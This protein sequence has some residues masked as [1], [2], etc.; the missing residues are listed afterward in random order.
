MQVGN[1][2]IPV[3]TMVLG[4]GFERYDFAIVAS[5]NP[6]AL[7]SV[8]ADMLWT[9]TVRSDDV[10]ALCQAAPEIVARAVKRYKSYRSKNPIVPDDWDGSKRWIHNPCEECETHGASVEILTNAEQTI[11]G[12]ACANDGDRCRCSD[13]CNGTMT[14]DGELLK[15]NWHDE[16]IIGIVRKG[17]KA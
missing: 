8:E 16:N 11:Q 6:F 10:Q 2:V 4:S 9:C 14:A 3:G 17:G 5:M 13:G 1:V 15:C 12:G 7:A